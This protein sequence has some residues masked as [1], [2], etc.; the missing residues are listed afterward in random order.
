MEATEEATATA[1]VIH[2]TDGHKQ[3]TTITTL[4]TD[5][6]AD[7]VATTATLITAMGVGVWAVEVVVAVA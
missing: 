6:L 5:P 4:A 1:R 3:I 2:T 7:K